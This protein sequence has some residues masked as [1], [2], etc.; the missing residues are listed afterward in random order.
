MRWPW[1]GSVDKVEIKEG[2]SVGGSVV[3]L[4]AD[5]GYMQCEKRLAPADQF[6]RTYLLGHTSLGFEHL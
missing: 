4:V 6:P 2:S 5:W 1:V 3:Q